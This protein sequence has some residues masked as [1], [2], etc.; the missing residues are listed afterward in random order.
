MYR[1]ECRLS[2]GPEHNN[3]DA[4]S[5]IDGEFGALILLLKEK[6]AMLSSASTDITF[7]CRQVFNRHG[8][9]GAG[10]SSTWRVQM[11]QES[12][13]VKALF[14]RHEM[15]HERTPHSISKSSLAPMFKPSMR[16]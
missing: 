13:P 16:A 10:N 15:K 12:S 7:V 1:E 11:G 6:V 2:A 3:E 9:S 5:T 8:L 14:R 4:V